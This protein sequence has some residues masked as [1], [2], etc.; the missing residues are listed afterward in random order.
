MSIFDWAIFDGFEW[1]DLAKIAALFAIGETKAFFIRRQKK[2][3]A[4]KLGTSQ[5]KLVM[6]QSGQLKYLN[7]FLY[8]LGGA[9]ILLTILAGIKAGFQLEVMKGIS[10]GI[11]L[12]YLPRALR[13]WKTINYG[14]SGMEFNGIVIKWDEL[15][16][17]EWDKDIN[18][19]SWG[20][21][22]YKRGEISPL[23]VY[24]KRK[25][26]NDFENKINNMLLENKT[27]S[28]VRPTV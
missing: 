12:I 7:Y 3:I 14:D 1:I 9:T 13:N 25:Y 11:G 24:V 15:E 27:A 26:K 22:F 6:M 4:N 21:K 8:G 18:Q 28:V 16:R 2:K 10:F 5:D 19:M 20:V 23:K 17:V